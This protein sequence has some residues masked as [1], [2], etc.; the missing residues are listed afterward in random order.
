MQATVGQGE[1]ESDRGVKN[2]TGMLGNIKRLNLKVT[3][4]D[5]EKVVI[6]EVRKKVVVVEVRIRIVKEEIEVPEAI[7]KV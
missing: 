1:G 2:L 3:V 7:I 6:V 4:P 5:H